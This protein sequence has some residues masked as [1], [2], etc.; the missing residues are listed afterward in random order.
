MY[1]GQQIKI[2]RD[3]KGL[4]QPQLS[5][6]I[7]IEQ[8]YLSK[9]E[10]NKSVPSNDIFNKILT[11][12]EVTLTDFLSAFNLKNDRQHLSQIPEIKLWFDQQNQNYSKNQ[13]MYLYFCCMFIVFSVAIF[14]IGMSKQVYSETMYHYK[15]LGEILDG[16]PKD[17][18]YQWKD[19]IDNN[20]AGRLTKISAKR[21]EMNLRKNYV[22]FLTYEYKGPEFEMKDKNGRRYYHLSEDIKIPRKINAW[23]KFFGV[24]IF[25]I[26]I[27]GFFLETRLVKN[28]ND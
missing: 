16:E 3:E 1:L 21:L 9:L 5:E 14:Y 26:G 11:V 22:Y 19:L 25:T 6:L 2:L 27:M 28:Y 18:F 13:R 12:L 8:S 20:Q 10:N 4:S 24:L 23:L 17:I 7:G 15:S